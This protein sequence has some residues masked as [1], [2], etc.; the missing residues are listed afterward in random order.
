MEKNQT[1]CSSKQKCIKNEAGICK[2]KDWCIYKIRK[3]A[4]GSAVCAGPFLSQHSRPEGPRSPLALIGV[5]FGGFIT[6][7]GSYSDGERSGNLQKFSKKGLIYKTHEGEL[8]MDGIKISK[9]GKNGSVFEFSVMDESIAKQLDTLVGKDITIKYE[10]KLHVS[11][12]DGST[13][14]IVKSVTVNK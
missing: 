6:S 7:F 13:D 3:K 9:N 12:H 14:Y 5:I 4:E 11:F 1:E 10:Q 2:Y 8:A